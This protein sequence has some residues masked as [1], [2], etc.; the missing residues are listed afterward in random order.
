MNMNTVQSEDGSVFVYMTGCS[1]DLS[2]WLVAMLRLSHY[3]PAI[4][5]T[6]PHNLVLPDTLRAPTS[7]LSLVQSCHAPRSA[8]LTQASA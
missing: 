4:A 2:H 1:R 8:L 6:K 5:M 3:H 7:L